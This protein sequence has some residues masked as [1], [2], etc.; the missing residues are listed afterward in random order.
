MDRD[1]IYSDDYFAGRGADPW[2]DYIFEL[3]HPAQTIRVY[4]WR[5]ILEAVK[6]LIRLDN[7][8]RWMDFSCGNGGLI[9]Y[10][11]EREPCHMTGCEDG[12]IARKAAAA[13]I[14]SLDSGQLESLEGAFDVVTAIEVLE[15]VADP[16]ATL[17]RIRR[18]LKP[19]GLFFYTTGNAAPQRRRFLKWRYAYPEVHI[20][21]YEPRT[22]HK[23]L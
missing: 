9:R 12:T 4:E 1:D 7:S 2:V 5:G 18:L 21:F 3:G 15:H 23:A 16:M 8:T 13:G 6:S 19:G 10:C 11:R 20:S 22:L 14:P 17:R